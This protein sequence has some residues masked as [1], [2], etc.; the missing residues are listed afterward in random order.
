[1]SLAKHG[2]NFET[3][4]NVY[5]SF[6]TAGIW[7]AND[8][9]VEPWEVIGNELQTSRF[10]ESWLAGDEGKA[11]VHYQVFDPEEKGLHCR[12]QPQRVNR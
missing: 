8:Y 6:Q 11:T 3:S 9:I 10:A 2:E 7:Q 4:M 1:M 5:Q 12:R